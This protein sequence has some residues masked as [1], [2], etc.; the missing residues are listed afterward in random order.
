MQ[1][2]SPDLAAASINAFAVD[3]H[4]V[5]ARRPGNLVTS[6]AS[7]ALAFLMLYEGARGA[8]AGELAR[9]FHL[10]ADPDASRSE[11]VRLLLRW[12]GQRDVLAVAN[13]LYAER[14]LALFPEFLA[15]LAERFGAPL[16]P[17]DFRGAAEQARAAINQWVAEHTHH[18]IRDLL[19]PPSVRPDTLL[20]LVNAVYFKNVW[21][22]PFDP[23]D[24]CRATFHA[25]GGTTIVPMMRRTDDLPLAVVADAG[26]RL[27]ELTYAGGE[28]SMVIVLPDARD[29]LPTVERAL[30]AE[31]LQRWLAGLAPRRVAVELP[32]FEL[33]PPK[34]L[35]LSTVLEQLGLVTIFDPGRADLGGI[36]DGPLVV[37]EAYHKAF[38]A[39][40]EQGTTAAAAT[41]VAMVQSPRPNPLEFRADHPFLFLVRDR[42]SGAILFLGRLDDPA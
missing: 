3:L 12:S 32:R 25:P 20:V 8:T 39:V 7:I 37:D 17:L 19:P 36:T 9:V 42:P 41:A 31:S 34:A 14:S 4:R 22:R 13:R 21:S 10:G 33:R 26:L 16:V 30:T 28:Q 27:I 40:D 24:T 2:S 18:K 11:F 23:D 38:I 1:S 6:P 15:R 35:A 29:G 5:L